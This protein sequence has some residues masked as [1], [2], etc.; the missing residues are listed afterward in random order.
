MVPNTCVIEPST[1]R[2]LESFHIV[3]ENP[4]GRTGNLSDSVVDA[5]VVGLNEHRLT[6]NPECSAWFHFAPNSSIGLFGLQI[7]RLIAFGIDQFKRSRVAS[8]ASPLGKNPQDL[9][10]FDRL[11]EKR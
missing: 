9:G 5:L 4:I 1:P 3:H 8:S 11:L 2:H 7:V 6:P 10:W